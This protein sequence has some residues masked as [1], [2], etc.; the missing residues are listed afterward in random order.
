MAF[1]DIYVGTI[2]GEVE[3]F[4]TRFVHQQSKRLLCDEG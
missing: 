4:H 2:E 3:A 1:V